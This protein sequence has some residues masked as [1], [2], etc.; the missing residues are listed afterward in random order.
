[1]ADRFGSGYGADG[2]RRALRWAEAGLGRGA[3]ACVWCGRQTGSGVASPSSGAASIGLAALAAAWM[4]RASGRALF[5]RVP[6]GPARDFAPPVPPLRTLC[7]GCRGRIPWITAVRCAACGRGEPCEDCG[8]RERPVLL[9]NRAAVRYTP[10]MK[11]LLAR[12]KYR[13]AERL[14]P[15]FE[16]MAGYAFL[17]LQPLWGDCRRNGA[18][19]V[20]AP[21]VVLTYVPLSER[22]LEERGFNQSEAMAAGIG[23]QFRLPV[24]PTLQ[25][26]RH[27]EKMSYKSRRE[28]LNSLDNAFAVRRAG[29]EQ[30]ARLSSS[31]S[32]PVNVVI[33]D[34]VYTTGSTMHR[35]AEIINA[36]H[37]PGAVRLFGLTWAR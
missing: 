6:P 18:A 5:R 19:G 25:R 17:Q 2:W 24:V 27:T 12:Y 23:R 7:A 20:P 15:L 31:I 32:A 26:T 11:E 29:M 9:A 3:S 13:G 22:R 35:C 30:L 21:R 14:L 33:V 28:R 4:R 34:D 37:P 16:R 10:F 36:W 8:R 1:M